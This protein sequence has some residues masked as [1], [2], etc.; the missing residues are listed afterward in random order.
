MKRRTFILFILLILPALILSACE[1]E[2]PPGMY[3][4]PAELTEKEEAVAKLL[5]ADTD[6]F[7]LDVM[8]DSTVRSVRIQYYE[9]IDGK[10]NPF[11]GSSV[12]LDGSE[13]K[14]RMAFR[15]GKLTGSTREAVQFGKSFTSAAHSIPEAEENQSENMGFGGSRLSSRVNIVY[16]EEIPLVLQVAT[17]KTN[18]HIYDTEY[19]FQPEVYDGL[20]YEHVYALTVTFSQEPL[21]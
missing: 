10:W 12:A 4:Q 18:V 7:I 11:N 3:I 19:F 1:S 9:L 8:V 20:G 15:Y 16:G 5:G 17:S 13:A 2:E 21:S 14:G 6:D